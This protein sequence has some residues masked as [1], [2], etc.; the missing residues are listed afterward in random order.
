MPML[1]LDQYDMSADRGFLCRHDASAVKLSG[2]FARVR[3]VAMRLPD[4][5]PTGRCR[6]ILER[7][8]PALNSEHVAALSDAQARMAMVHL[9]LIHI[10]EPTRR[11]PIS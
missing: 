10:S 1:T 3:D 2:E 4:Y 6:D 11:T 8:V 7:D 5:L 9:S